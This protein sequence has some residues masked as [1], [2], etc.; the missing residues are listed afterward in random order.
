MKL[1]GEKLKLYHIAAVPQAER[2]TR[3]I[4]NLSAPLDK[5][6]H[7]VNGATDRKISQESMQF[8]RALPRILQAIWEVDP[9]EGPVRVSRLDVTDA[10][11]RGT[12]KLSQVGA[13]TYV[14]PLIPDDDIILIC[15]DLVLPIRWVDSPEFFCAF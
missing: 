4:L 2:W 9:E 13:F 10:Y 5:E 15:I 3:L 12:L 1:F 8:G 11:H 6:T 7:S 14:V